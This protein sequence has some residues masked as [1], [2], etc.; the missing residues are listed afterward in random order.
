MYLTYERTESV[1]LSGEW[2]LSRC[3]PRTV[4]VGEH[5]QL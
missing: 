1:E 4:V 2:F 5:R 3:R